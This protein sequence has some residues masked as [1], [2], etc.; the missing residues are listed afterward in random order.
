MT[1]QFVSN[2]DTDVANQAVAES[3]DNKQTTNQKLII[4]TSY[5]RRFKV[6]QAPNSNYKV[7]LSYY[8]IEYLK[9]LDYK[10]FSSLFNELPAQCKTDM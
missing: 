2:M 6:R 7:P 3:H 1:A 5:R 8:F 4:V 9:M 10:A